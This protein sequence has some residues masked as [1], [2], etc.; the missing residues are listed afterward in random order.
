MNV[1]GLIT[2][3]LAALA[4]TGV[5]MTASSEEPLP[6]KRVSRR[7]EKQIVPEPIAEV[8]P[9]EKEPEIKEEKSEETPQVKDELVQEELIPQETPEEAFPSMLGPRDA[10]EELAQAY[11][12]TNLQDSMLNEAMDVKRNIRSRPAFSRLGDR[13]N[14][15]AWDEQIREV[16]NQI[17][18]SGQSL[19]EFMDNSW[20]PIPEQLASLWQAEDVSAVP[21]VR[22]T[23]RRT[24]SREAL[25]E[26]AFLTREAMQDISV[27]DAKEAKERMTE[28][29]SA[30]TRARQ[31]DLNIPALSADQKRALEVW[32][33]T[34]P[35]LVTS[36]LSL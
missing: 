12:Y 5:V 13:A 4:L 27:K 16:R 36:L 34:E 18:E 29:L 19:S 14:P 6:P 21:E 28:I 24:M 1:A 15:S 3:G 2:A 17:R 23:V 26:A 8:Q 25:A 11:T 32:K 33:A 22:S 20:T 9:V 30:R 35:T 31:L 7:K 10:E